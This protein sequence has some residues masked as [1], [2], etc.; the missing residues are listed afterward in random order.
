MEMS[1]VKVEGLATIDTGSAIDEMLNRWLNDDS[2]ISNEL[3]KS[4]YRNAIKIFVKFLNDSGRTLDKAAVKAYRQWLTANRSVSTARNYFS[5]LRV[6]VKWLAS[7]DYCPNYT[8]DVHTVKLDT[9]EHARD[10]L[11]LDEAVSVLK[12]FKGNDIQSVRDKAIMSLLLTCGLRTIEIIRIDI[13]D[14]ERR[15]GQWRLKIWGKGRA[16]KDASVILPDE[17]KKLI[18]EYLRLRG[19]TKSTEPL[20]VSISRR[21]KN[22][23]LQRQSISR[24]AKKSFLA[25][26]I[27]STKIVAHSCRHFCATTA[28]DEGC[29]LDEV[30]KNLRHK[31]VATSE[32]YR[33]DRISDTNSTTRVVAAIL[34]KRLNE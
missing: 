7:Q 23:R 26:G 24:L 28:L 4:S 25:A 10:S 34:F 3:T 1:I 9:S 6:F 15:R 30:S 20:F 18:D 8:A 19:K 17:T 29:S 2:D 22:E 21:N 32:I 12:S 14:M 33:H 13:G 31:S 16:G 27:Q 5:I 11:T